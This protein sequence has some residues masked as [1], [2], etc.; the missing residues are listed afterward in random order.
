LPANF[1][2]FFKIDKKS[3]AQDSQPTQLNRASSATSITPSKDPEKIVIL[4][5]A[6]GSAPPLK[7]NKFKLA[8][9]ATIRR[10]LDFLRQQ[11][12]FT[13]DQPLYVFVNSAFQPH[14]DEII[15]D[16]YRCFQNDGKL[17]LNYCNT[18]AWG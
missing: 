4:F 13:P 7:Q 9:E 11:L 3:M 15:R 16:L 17:V 8:S 18:V 14:P 12:Q 2:I 1:F 6:A 10:L 5:Q